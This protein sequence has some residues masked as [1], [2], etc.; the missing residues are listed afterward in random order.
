MSISLL[1]PY[2]GET[3][4]WLRGNLHTHTTNSDGPLSPQ[5]T[6]DVYAGQGYD[7][8]M[9]S[10][11]DMLSDVTD[12]DARG[13][14]LL[15]GNE[16]TTGGPHLL[17]VGATRVIP[18]Y[19]DRQRVIDEI[20][21]AGGFAVFC[22]PNW[23]S[24]FNH[25]PQEKL[26]QFQGYAGI[27]IFN[28]V[29]VWVE[30]NPYATDRWDRLLSQGR[31]VWGFADDD[32]HVPTDLGVGWSMVQTDGDRSVRAILGALR[33]GR[34]YASTGVFIERITASGP[35]VEVHT[36]DEA[37][38]SVMSNHGFRRATSEGKTLSFTVP[39]DAGYTYIRIECAGFGDRKAWS[40]PFFITRT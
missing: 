18:P 2:R 15:P 23:E 31:R 5:E 8:L 34:F 27:E 39:D 30:G 3:T 17:H 21:A 7:F 14:T 37:R 29:T 16:I 6:I 33:E 25:C 38:I 11:H 26:E 28:G 20:A 35:T 22:H 24:H 40:Q 19:P 10:D 32:C 12:L 1:S 13:M 9:L 36:R 4:S